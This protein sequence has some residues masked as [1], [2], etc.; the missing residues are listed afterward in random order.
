MLRVGFL[1]N[2]LGLRGTEVAMFDYADL[3]ETMLGNESIIISFRDAKPFGNDGLHKFLKRFKVVLL[4]DASNIDVV[5]RDHRLDSLYIIKGGWIDDR[6]VTSCKSCIHAVFR[7]DTPHGDAF[8]VI[9]NFVNAKHGTS[10]SEIPHIVRTC[11]TT[12]ADLRNQ[13]GI[14]TDA[15]VFGRHGGTDSFDMPEAKDAV[16]SVAMA[17]P[18]DRFFVFMNT[19]RFGPNL[20]NLIFLPGTPDM[21]F[22]QMFINTCDAMIHARRDGETFGLSCAEFAIS[23][24]RVYTYRHCKDTHHIDALGKNA[25]LYTGY[26]DLCE[27]LLDPHEVRTRVPAYTEY[28]PENIMPLFRNFINPNAVVVVSHYHGELAW[29]NKLWHKTVVYSKATEAEWNSRSFFGISPAKPNIHVCLQENRGNEALAY[30]AFIVTNYDRLP[31]ETVFVHDHDRS[32]HHDGSIVDK[33]HALDMRS[34]SYVNLN[35]F[36]RQALKDAGDDPRIAFEDA[37]IAFE[38]PPS[39]EDVSYDSCAMFAVTRDRIIARPL[40]FYQRCLTYIM[41]SQTP[42]FYVSRLFEYTWAWM[43]D[44]D[45]RGD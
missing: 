3:N 32:W 45:V 29:V 10:Y 33:I 18:V 35:R 16:V 4:D 17:R 26:A 24:K 15:V 20:P 36:P 41:T 23:G 2:Q 12:E 34:H 7:S 25:I 9:S 5:A 6:Y 31:D 11:S 19:D 21:D 8:A 37:H 38:N 14:P 28:S 42:T 22:K 39:L 43:F 1:S 44:T 40:E 13:L 27:K 30:L